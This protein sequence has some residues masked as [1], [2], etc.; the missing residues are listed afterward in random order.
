MKCMKVKTSNY[1]RDLSAPIQIFLLSLTFNEQKLYSLINT[2]GVISC[3]LFAYNIWVRSYTHPN[4]DTK[5]KKWILM[6]WNMFF[7]ICYCR[8]CCAFVYNTVNVWSETKMKLI[9]PFISDVLRKWHFSMGF[10]ENHIP[11]SHQ[12]SFM[13]KYL[14]RNIFIFCI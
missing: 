14:L 12:Y 9:T 7:V 11:V 8:W 3:D 1:S 13:Q 2:F 5:R 10:D 6:W 4:R